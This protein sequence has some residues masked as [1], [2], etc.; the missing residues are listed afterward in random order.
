MLVSDVL[1][2]PGENGMEGAHVPLRVVQH[3]RPVVHN[4][5]VHARLVVQASQQLRGQQEVLQKIN[6]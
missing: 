1:A 5:H 2:A 4:Q 6:N 3:G